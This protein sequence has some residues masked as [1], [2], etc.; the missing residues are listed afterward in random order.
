[1]FIVTQDLQFMDKTSLNYANL[2][3]YQAALGL[4]GQEYRAQH[5]MAI[6]IFFWGLMVILTTQSQTYSS[7]FIMGIFEAA[8][9]PCVKFR[10]SINSM[11]LAD[12]SQW[13]DTHDGILVHSKGDSSAAVYLVI[14]SYISMGVSKLPVDMKPERWELI[15]YVL[16]GVTCL[17]AFLI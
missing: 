14:G 11:L 12:A 4:K 7:A 2:F 13:F 15:F 3:G 9:T 8:V 5:V 10:I 16:G 1:M 6:S 17:W